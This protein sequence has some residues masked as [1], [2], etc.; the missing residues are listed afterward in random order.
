MLPL[1]VDVNTVISSLLGEGNSLLVFKM[2]DLLKK[3]Y[4]ISP[5]FFLIEI[6]KH[7]SEIAE[8]SKL[9]IIE[10]TKVM[11]FVSQQIQF[12]SASDFE[13]KFHDARKILEDHEKDVHYLALALKYNCDILSGDKTFKTLCPDK[14]KNTREIL[15]ELNSSP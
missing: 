11:N 9:S 15:E 4:F 7:T 5:E 1:V 12:V 13:D 8:R 10:A 14:V 2:N 3:Y 6:G